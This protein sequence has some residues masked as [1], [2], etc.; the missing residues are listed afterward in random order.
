MLTN[1]ENDVAKAKLIVGILRAAGYDAHIVGGAL[2]V[3]ALGGSTQDVDIAVIVDE[4][5]EAQA[6]A[7]DI[8]HILFSP[9]GYHF[10]MQHCKIGYESLNGFLAD[11]RYENVNVIAYDKAV[12]SDV[13]GL[14]SAFDLNINQWYYDDA[15]VLHNDHFD[16]VTKLVKV[17][18]ERDNDFQ[19]KRLDD[20]VT[21][22]K[23]IYPELDW[24]EVDAQRPF[25]KLEGLL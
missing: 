1:F 15:G 10:S 13:Y 2:R 20:R 23:D 4:Y 5:G 19:M 3:L 25:D 11:W 8:G 12:V 17:N 7:R 14:V 6:F 16:P 18:P 22:F 21:R 9:M 24:S